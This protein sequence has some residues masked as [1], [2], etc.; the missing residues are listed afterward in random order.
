M[1]TGD[2]RV[3]R[4][5]MLVEATG[6]FGPLTLAWFEIVFGASGI[7]RLTGGGDPAPDVAYASGPA[8]GAA[9]CCCLIS[10]SGARHFSF[11]SIADR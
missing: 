10:L 8:L 9:G 11:V 7:V 5:V 2:Y 6:A 4:G 3:S 1:N